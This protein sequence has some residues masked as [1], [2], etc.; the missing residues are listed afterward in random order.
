MSQDNAHAEHY[1]PTWKEYKWVALILFLIT[2]V[3]V[4]VY[5]IPE[6][7]ASKAFVPGLLIM[8]AVK[9]AIVVMYYMHLKYDHKLFRSLFVGPLLVAILTLLGLLFLFSKIAIRLSG[10]G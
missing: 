5:Y 8:S 2:V 10:G 3:E 9:F 4:W 7:V 1:H 6:L